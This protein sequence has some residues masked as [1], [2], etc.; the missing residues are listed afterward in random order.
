MED[1]WRALGSVAPPEE[2]TQEAFDRDDSHLRR[3]VRLRPGQRAEARDL[4]DYTQDL[5]YT[6]IQIPLFVY[7]LPFCLSAWREDLRGIT[8]GYAG[9]VE[10]FYPVLANQ[11]IFKEDLT[12]NQG[13]ALSEFIRQTILEEIDDQRGLS[14]KGTMAR[15]YRWVRALT[16]Y[17]VLRP[18]VDRLWTSWW[19]LTTVG[20]AIATVQ[21]FSC[22]MYAEDENPVFAPWTHDEGGGP[23]CLWEFDGHLYTHRWLQSIVVFLNVALTGRQVSDVLIRA[24]ERLIGQSEHQAAS[25]IRDDLPLC[26]ETVEARCAELPLLLA[27][28]QEPGSVVKINWSK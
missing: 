14:Y 11:R 22:L 4:W 1:L 7:L 28:T 15:P 26:I 23:P 2:I 16:T 27:T 25:G 3:L 13:A 19:S 18:D 20:R 10:W 9:F 17:G 6:E 8:S 24:V 21:Y 12:P 5:L